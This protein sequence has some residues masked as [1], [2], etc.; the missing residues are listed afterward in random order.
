VAPAARDRRASCGAAPDEASKTAILLEASAIARDRAHD[1]SR[2]LG[3][4]SRTFALAPTDTAVESELLR[5]AEA[6][7]GWR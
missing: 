4:V 6:T 5:L 1:P 7:S 3:F 2:A